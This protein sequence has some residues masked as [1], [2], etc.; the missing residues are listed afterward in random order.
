MIVYRTYKF[1][2]GPTLVNILCVCIGAALVVGAISLLTTNMA[3]AIILGVIG[4]VIYYP[5]GFIL[6]KKWADASII[7]RLRTNPAFCAKYCNYYR[8]AYNYVCQINPVF[9]R[10]YA[11]NEKG[12]FV[13][14]SNQ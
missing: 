2:I 11:P 3:T 1:C 8:D 10:T 13:P 5:I 4:I 12:N 6:T 7:K 9:A 14:I